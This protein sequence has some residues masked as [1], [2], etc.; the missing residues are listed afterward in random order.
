MINGFLRHLTLP[1]I[2]A[3]FF[4]HDIAAATWKNAAE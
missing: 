2:Y 3:E 1:K 4:W